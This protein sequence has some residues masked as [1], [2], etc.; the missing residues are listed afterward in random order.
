MTLPDDAVFP[1]LRDEFVVGWQ[2]IEKHKYVGDSFGYGGTSS[3]VGTTNGAGAHNLQIFVLSPDGV[4]LHALFGF[5]HPEDLARE[6]R[7]AQE[8]ARLWQDD[9][10]SRAEKDDMYRRLQLAA[11]RRH[12]PETFAR[13][14]WQ[15]F[16]M[17]FEQ[18]RLHRGLRD[19][20]FSADGKVV[21]DENGRPVLKPLNVL[22]HERMAARPFVEFEDFDVAA[23][24]DYGRD[25]YD[26]NLGLDEGRVF[27]R[28]RATRA[29]RQFEERRQADRADRLARRAEARAKPAA[30]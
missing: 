1:L 10:R 2:N 9:G 25:F 29:K 27:Q 14:R 7:L 8:L 3:S 15:G 22:V 13:S 21:T 19:T 4:V 26:N 12:P 18:G 16:D 11:V 20:F 6:L 23:F 24:T 5:W 17:Q 28:A 30:R